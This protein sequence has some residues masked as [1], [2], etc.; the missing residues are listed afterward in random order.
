MTFALAARCPRT[1]MIGAAV[2][3][4]SLAV[5]SRCVFARASVGAVLTQHRTDPRLGPKILARLRSGAAPEAIV[6]ELAA[7]AERLGWRLA[8]L[9]TVLAALWNLL[10]V[11][12]FIYVQRPFADPGYLGLLLGQLGAVAHLPHVLGGGAALSDLVLSPMIR[13]QAAS[14]TDGILLLAAIAAFVALAYKVATF[15]DDG[16]SRRE[17]QVAEAARA[18]AA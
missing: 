16:T 17:V 15:R 5:G 12:N 1:G 14:F 6:K 10:L 8:G 18:S 3:T 9:G 2:T 7:L 13:H 4:S 11:A